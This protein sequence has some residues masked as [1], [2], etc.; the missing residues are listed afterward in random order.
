MGTAGT[1]SGERSCSSLPCQTSCGSSDGSRGERSFLG[2]FSSSA[3][4]S[5]SSSVGIL[6]R[7]PLCLVAR[8][9][10]G[11]LGLGGILIQNQGNM[12]LVLLIGYLGLTKSSVS[13]KSKLKPPS[14]S[15]LGKT[16]RCSDSDAKLT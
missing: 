1:S 16:N 3:T 2:A 9:G 8:T 5:R 14:A 13:G 7:L 15:G 11:D 12:E 4:K 10:V 6:A